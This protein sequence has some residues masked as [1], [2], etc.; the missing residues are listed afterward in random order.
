MA[1]RPIHPQFKETFS[2]YGSVP[3]LIQEGLWNYM[4][5]GLMPGGF[6]TAVLQ[7][8]FFAAM[9][10]ADHTWSG[11]SFKDLAKW[12]DNYMPR[13]MRGDDKSMSQWMQ[14]TD[15][16]RRDI[17]I[18]LGLRPNEFDILRGTAVA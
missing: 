10:R 15:E 11:R 9:A 16:E 13:Y 1:Y 2:Y 5:F 17:M 8:D 18:E 3:E 14:K 4:A 6:M 12:I 7:N